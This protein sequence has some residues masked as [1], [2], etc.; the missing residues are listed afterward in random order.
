MS[1]PSGLALGLGVFVLSAAGLCAGEKDAAVRL[2]PLEGRVRIEI[3]GEMFAEYIFGRDVHKPYLYPI[4]LADG[5]NVTR[6][7]PMKPAAPGERTDHPHHRALWYAHGAVNGHDFW[8]ARKTSGRIVFDEL[9]ETR[10]GAAG[11]LRAR[12]RWEAP[13]GKLVATDEVTVRVEAVPQGRLLDY[14]IILHAQ[15]DRPLTFGDTKEGTM[16]IRLAQ[17]MV[18]PHTARG[19]QVSGAGHVLS[20][21]G[22][23]DAAAW[24]KRAEWVDYFAPHE[25]KTYGV[26]IFDHP[27]NPRHPTWWHVRDYGLFA[28]NPFGEHDFEGLEDQPDAG[29]FVVPPGGSVTFR[30][31]FYIHEGDT[32]AAGVAA[33]YRDYAGGR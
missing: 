12:H 10:S 32:D 11:V 33:R 2:V 16:A 9:L 25:D 20:S 21:T 5:T 3:D 23:R 22:K 8:A 28:A 29:E 4:R 18:M 27:Q 13:D 30:Y 7:H 31:R 17:W 19:E 15:P 6:D 24:G 1:G 26:A 14:E